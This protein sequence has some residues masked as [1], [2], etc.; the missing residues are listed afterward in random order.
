MEKSLKNENK[1][2]KLISGKESFVLGP[3]DGIEILVNA[4]KTFAYINSN[5][6]K[7][8]ADEKGLPTGETPV[9][10]YEMIKDATFSQMFSSL[11]SDLNNLCLTQAQIKG[12]VRNYRNWLRA[13]SHAT[14]FLFR[15][16]N[17]FFVAYVC[18]FF[19]DRLWVFV[20]RFEDSNVWC[21]RSCHRVVVPQ[22]A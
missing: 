19:G 1:F 20:S 4:K 2:L 21:V 6:V 10:V 7:Y 5:F 18:V 22:L 12:F 15:S 17:R 14:F 13:D 9:V 11:S 16:H 3:T 8:G